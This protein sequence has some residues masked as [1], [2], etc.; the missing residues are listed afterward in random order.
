[1]NSIKSATKSLSKTVTKATSNWKWTQ[2]KYVL[3]VVV[4]IAL[5]NAVSYVSMGHFTALAAF[6]LFG[7]AASYLTKNMT[8]ILLSAVL[9]T[10]IFV[11]GMCRPVREGMENK[12][13]EE[14]E[15][16]DD[17]SDVARI[18]EKATKLES[19]KTIENVL[20]KDGMK[21]MTKDTKD[22]MANQEQLL[23]TVE[24]MAPMIGQLTDMMDKMQNIKMPEM[25]NLKGLF[26]AK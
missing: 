18:D 1:M 3:Y 11:S 2:N 25:P 8:L 23:K 5:F 22:L 26:G 16:D 6:I 24:T 12:E 10:N 14:E 17:V 15:E 19:L 4:A 21:N 9:L 7:I 13:E 20:G